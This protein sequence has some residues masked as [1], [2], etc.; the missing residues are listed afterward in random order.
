[1]FAL[2]QV[3]G[4]VINEGYLSKLIN[5]T[6]AVHQQLTELKSKVNEIGNGLRYCLSVQQ[7]SQP[8]LAQPQASLF[9]NASSPFVQNANGFFA[10]PQASN[11][12]TSSGASAFQNVNLPNNPNNVGTGPLYTPPFINGQNY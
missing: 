8:V 10:H 6:S 11:V 12:S 9:G 2:S 7:M 5:Q 4:V 3:S 1:M